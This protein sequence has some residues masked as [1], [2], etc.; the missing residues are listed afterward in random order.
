MLTDKSFLIT[1]PMTKG[2]G[3][4]QVTSNSIPAGELSLYI[5]RKSGANVSLG[6]IIG[7]TSSRAGVPV[8]E[9]AFAGGVA[10]GVFPGPAGGVFPGPA[11]GVFPGPAGGVFPR[12]TGGVFPG[13]AGGVFT[14]PA[15]DAWLLPAHTKKKV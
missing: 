3:R 10:G 8:F 11:G 12:P 7:F 5:V 2:A 4:L 13:P 1:L 9:S 6:S 15:G 14:G